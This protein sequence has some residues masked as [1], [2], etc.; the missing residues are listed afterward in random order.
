MAFNGYKQRSKRKKFFVT[1]SP[2]EENLKYSDVNLQSMEISNDFIFSHNDNSQS[3]EISMPYPHHT[4]NNNIVCDSASKGEC[5]NDYDS[6]SNSDYIWVQKDFKCPMSVNEFATEFV[7]L[8]AKHKTSDLM[9]NEVLHLIH[10]IIPATSSLPKQYNTL[11]SSL[12]SEKLHVQYYCDTCSIE[13]NNSFCTICK[14]VCSQF[15]NLNIQSQLTKIVIENYDHMVSYLSTSL[16][17]DYNCRGDFITS[18]A[19]SSYLP[20][21]NEN[22]E[23]WINLCVSSDGIPIIKNVIFTGIQYNNSKVIFQIKVS[24]IFMASPSF[25]P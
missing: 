3:K 14:K 2:C 21:P 8:Q 13:I 10:R 24:I 9:M 18:D 25:R 12:S 19:Y 16:S 23:F 15:C 4:E 6:F 11:R 1:P 7:G 5:D 22:G 20:N 17:S